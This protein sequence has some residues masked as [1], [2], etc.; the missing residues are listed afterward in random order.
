MSV[1]RPLQIIIIILLKQM[2]CFTSMPIYDSANLIYNYC[3][4][5]LWVWFNNAYNIMQHLLPYK[6][7]YVAPCGSIIVVVA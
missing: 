7:G 3:Q 2:V 5:S 1:S 6:T 4:Q